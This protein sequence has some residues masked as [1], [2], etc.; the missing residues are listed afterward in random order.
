MVPGMPPPPPA[1]S[2]RVLYWGSGSPP[3]WRVLST[4]HE[5]GLSYRSEM[6]TFESGILKTAPMLSLNPRG[7]VS[8]S[9]WLLQHPAFHSL[10]APR[11]HAL[12]SHRRAAL[13]CIALQVPIF[14]DGD[15]RMYE[16]L[17]ILHYLETFY[18]ETPLLPRERTARARAL[19]RMEEANN[20]S[21]AA[22]EVVYYVRRTPPAEINEEYLS[23]KKG[24]LQTELALWETYLVG[25][26]YLAGPGYGV[27]LP[28]L[29]FFPSLAYMVR[30]GL[31]LEG[32]YPNL[33]G[34]FERMVSRP[35]IQNTW[36]PHWKKTPGLPILA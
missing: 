1:A 3:A 32:R 6:I 22:G 29:A 26:D 2:P 35:S 8:D 11:L 15:V 30:L 27:T 23:A 31:K 9:S 24:A 18:P 5:K 19:T 7:L 13:H 4:L 25:T 14:I 20:V 33:L 10:F 16:S 21:A 12:A 17:A 34:Y 36:P 28:D